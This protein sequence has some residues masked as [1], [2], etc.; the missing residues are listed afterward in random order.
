M[1]HSERLYLS[2]KPENK[3]ANLSAFTKNEPGTVGI[4]IHL[5]YALI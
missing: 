2:P 1:R 4:V 3:I 5:L